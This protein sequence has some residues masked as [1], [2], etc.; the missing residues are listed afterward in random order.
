MGGDRREESCRTRHRPSPE[1]LCGGTKER[2]PG[3]GIPLAFPVSQWRLSGGLAREGRVPVTVAGPRRICTGFRVA[4]FVIACTAALVYRLTPAAAREAAGEGHTTRHPPARVREHPPGPA[5]PR[6]VG[7]RR[8]AEE[9]APA[10]RLLRYRSSAGRNDSG[11]P[12]CLP[13]P[14]RIP[15]L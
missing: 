9:F 12:D 1:G 14:D 15:R 8:P 3:F 13:A 6:A 11:S 4:P 10:R 5:T 2:S 7:S